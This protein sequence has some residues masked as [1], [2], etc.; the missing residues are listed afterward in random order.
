MELPQLGRE[1]KAVVFTAMQQLGAQQ[2]LQLLQP[3]GPLTVPNLTTT[4]L[5]PVPIAKKG[6]IGA[7]ITG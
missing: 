1:I 5:A 7:P 6:F 4:D 2:A 3:T